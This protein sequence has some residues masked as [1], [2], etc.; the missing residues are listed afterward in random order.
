MIG[1]FQVHIAGS[2]KF[3]ALLRELLYYYCLV[4]L[5]FKGSSYISELSSIYGVTRGT[6]F[7]GIE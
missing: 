6:F 2:T 4:S 3:Y 7:Q 5:I 1:S